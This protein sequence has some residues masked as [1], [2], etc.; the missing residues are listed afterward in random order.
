MNE[1]TSQGIQDQIFHISNTFTLIITTVQWIS[2]LER[3]KLIDKAYLLEA[4]VEIRN[5]Q[6]SIRYDRIRFSC[7]SDKF[8]PF[9]VD[10]SQAGN[11]YLDGSMIFSKTFD[12]RMN[13]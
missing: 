2:S 9:S 5:E 1:F 13:H 8:D 6:E 12:D 4:I 11:S 7:S 10:N 3:E